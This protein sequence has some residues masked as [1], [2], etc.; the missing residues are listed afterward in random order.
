MTQS[1]AAGTA[2]DYQLALGGLLPPPG[3]IV[4]QR[5][6]DSTL[7]THSFLRSEN[8]A[9][10]LSKKNALPISLCTAGIAI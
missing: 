7:R 6:L 3:I 4:S 2:L 9:S 5:G 8:D 10:Y 1:L